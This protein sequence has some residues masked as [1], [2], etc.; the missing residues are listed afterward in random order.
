MSKRKM[1]FIKTVT[2]SL[3]VSLSVLPTTLYSD[4]AL[5]EGSS[6]EAKRIEEKI[7]RGLSLA[8]EAISIAEDHTEKNVD[9]M[10]PVKKGKTLNK[11]KGNFK[12]ASDR[13]EIAHKQKSKVHNLIITEFEKILNKKNNKRPQVS[14]SK[15]I[16]YAIKVDANRP[17]TRT[18]VYLRQ[19][20]RVLIKAT[21]KIMPG[22]FEYRYKNTS[23]LA[24][25][26][27]F[28]RGNFTVLPNT[29]YMAA[30]GKIGNRDAFYIGSGREFVTYV[31]GSLY[32]GINELNMSI[33]TGEPINKRS[34]YWK[35][36][37]GYFEADIYVYRK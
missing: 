25:G 35:D 34:I 9:T 24:G 37:T 31:D 10:N 27:H 12:T 28:T 7:N 4:D 21:G 6:V 32:L 1:L 11:K 18:R 33:Y 14:V 8:L 26:Y 13:K 15:P 29:R 2:A 3:F 36:N 22:K 16:H 5:I 23:C 30:I 17:W 19:G 20:D